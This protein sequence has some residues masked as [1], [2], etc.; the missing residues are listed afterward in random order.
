MRN[1][2]GLTDQVNP[3]ITIHINSQ[4]SMTFCQF[5]CPG[6]VKTPLAQ[7]TYRRQTYVYFKPAK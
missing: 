6:K 2:H 5:R 7:R 3:M 4:E 1:P